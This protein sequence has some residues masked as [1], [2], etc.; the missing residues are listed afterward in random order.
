MNIEEIIRYKW[1]KHAAKQIYEYGQPTDK[2]I[3]EFVDLCKKEAIG[4]SITDV[5]FQDF[6]DPV[7]NDNNGLRLL[8]ISGIEGVN[9][10]VPG[11][12]LEFKEG[13]DITV[14]YGFNGSGKSSYVRLLKHV[15]DAHIKGELLPNVYK[16]K[17]NN[18]QAQEA[19][20]TFKK[21]GKQSCIDW[22]ASKN[23]EQLT[24]VN[25]F[26]H[27][28]GEV[29]DKDFE[30]SYEPPKLSFITSLIK[31]CDRVGGE[32]SA[33]IQQHQQ[34]IP[35]IPREHEHSKE[36]EWLKK[37]NAQIPDT[38][39]EQYC[40]FNDKDKKR[41][42]GL[43]FPKD[44]IENLEKKKQAIKALLNDVQKHLQQ[45]SDEAYKRVISLRKTYIYKKNVADVAAKKEFKDIPLEGVGLDTWKGLWNAAR[46]YSMEKAY[47]GRTFPV[48]E[49]EDEDED[50]VCVLCHQS[51][52]KSAQD[53]F[54]EFEDYVQGSTLGEA[55]KAHK[56]WQAALEKID[57]ISDEET[58]VKNIGDAGMIENDHVKKSLLSLYVSLRA[59]K[60]KLSVLNS[61]SETPVIPNGQCVEDIIKRISNKYE[62]DI[63][64]CSQKTPEADKELASLNARKWFSEN[65][66]AVEEEIKHRQC[67]GKNSKG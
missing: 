52:S 18:Q 46:K 25:I 15:C 20:I 21:D 43:N 19:K 14:V 45:L 47:K 9:S 37:I 12:S 38:E 16:Y 58:L 36:A 50:A 2:D 53:R 1:L 4:E 29:L 41:L 28:Y 22:V 57:D 60:E 7:Q 5:H 13:C 64:K 39:L 55:N 8:S 26:D 17:S 61:E 31:V 6:H 65:R 32:L 62:V 49:I 33:E 54:N 44:K 42:E 66:A 24:S 35:L 51:L 27:T 34:K 63:E 59:R 11:K 67:I 23:C 56:A 30:V 40:V 3:S 48:V 10:L